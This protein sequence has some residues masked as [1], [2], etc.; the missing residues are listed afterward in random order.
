[1]CHTQCC[2]L[3]GCSYIYIYIYICMHTYICMYLCMR[4]HFI[5][6]HTYYV[7]MQAERPPPLKKKAHSLGALSTVSRIRMGSP[8][9]PYSRKPQ[10]PPFCLFFPYCKAF[11]SRIRMGSPEWPYSRKSPRPPLFSFF[12]PT[13]RLFYS[14]KSARAP[15]FFLFFF[16][17]L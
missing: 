2:V 12:F 16:C 8:E 6:I 13:V 7:Y 9:W 1:V 15:L 5:Y 10:A 3:K 4:I 11:L 14:R 17:L